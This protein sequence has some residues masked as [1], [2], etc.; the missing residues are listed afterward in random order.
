MAHRTHLISI[1]AVAVA[2]ALA[3]PVAQGGRGGA[4]GG[5]AGGRGA[6]PGGG[7]GGQGR[8][9]APRDATA[10]NAVGTA[11]IVGSVVVEGSGAAVRRARVTLTGTELRGTRSA[12]T[13][14]QGRFSFTALPAGRFTMTASKAGY[15]DNTYGAR[16]AGRPGT[17]IQLADGQRLDRATIALP[18]GGVITGVVVDE[19]GEPAPGTQVRALRYVMRTGERS[20]QQAGQDTTDDRGVY[21]IYQL[22]PGDYVVNALPRNMTATDL[23]QAITNEISSVVQQL[24]ASGV[25]VGGGRGAGNIDI[26]ALA[27][28]AAGRGAALGGRLAALQQQLEGSST[29]PTVAYAPVFYPGTTVAA[30]AST[31]S[32]GVSEERSS[33][34]FQLQLVAT[35]RVTGLV[36]HP[37]G[38]L[39]NGTQVGLVAA[40]RGATPNVPGIGNPLTRV[41]QDGRFTFS[42]VTPGQYLLQARATIRQPTNADAANPAP[43]GGG[44]GQ[45]GAQGAVTEVLW[46]STPI[47]VGGAALPDVVL[48]LQPGL[49]VTGR[50]VFETSTTATAT[51]PI[52]PSRARVNLSARGQ[53]IFEIGGGP[54]AAQ[55]D[56]SG[57]FTIVGVSPGRYTV[58]GTIAPV[59]GAAR[60]TGPGGALAAGG[61]RGG[62]A[63]PGQTGTSSWQLKSAVADGRD[64]LDFPVDLANGSLSNLTLTFSDTSQELS[65]TIQ[66]AAG[67]PI[68]DFTIIVFPP[69]QRYWLPQARRIASARPGTDGRFIFRGLPAGD[70]RLTAVTD[71][72]PG[73]WY[74]PAFLTQLAS[75]SIPVSIGEGEKKVQDIR[76]A[77]GQ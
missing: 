76:L 6:V 77:S 5:G 32:L 2:L 37:T 48:N 11:S 41:G 36:V 29:E 65:G 66:D 14:D 24:Q 34:D 49:T 21:R 15:V 70:Y 28:L 71:V 40:D 25:N 38:A 61:G 33:V 7:P 67:R 52:D 68:P 56:A 75:V 4:Q 73:E 58:T 42:N 13:D 12:L 1:T 63:L 35:S 45:G 69:D 74:D 57:R 23:Q 27:G 22:Q 43:A 18:R 30:Q 10:Q 46:A 59:G 64:L 9:N 50:V 51:A 55:A 72:E 3:Y 47:D 16:R 31:I 44:R 17:Q 54:T 8:G 62:A 39:P 26:G 20:L 19:H 60:A 53:Q